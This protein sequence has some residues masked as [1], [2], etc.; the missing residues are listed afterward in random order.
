M[1]LFKT[2]SGQL[3]NIWWV[4]IFFLVLAAITFRFIFGIPLKTEQHSFT[5]TKSLNHESSHL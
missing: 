5:Q 2:D 4:A 1:K 3:R